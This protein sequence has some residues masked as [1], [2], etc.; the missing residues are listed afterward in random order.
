MIAEFND[1][2]LEQF[3]P[4]FL[5]SL[6]KELENKGRAVL[7]N[8]ALK[9]RANDILA[10][11]FRALIRRPVHAQMLCRIALLNSNATLTQT[12][13]YELYQS[14]VHLI[15]EREAGKPARQAID[16]RQ[17]LIFMMDIAWYFWPDKG[18][19]GFT[20]EQ[21]KS[22]NIQL[23]EKVRPNDDIH[24]EMLVGSL[25]EKK[26]SSLYYFAHRSFQEYL[27]AEYIISSVDLFGTIDKV[28]RDLTP[29]I[30]A[31][32]REST[33]AETFSR[34]LFD[35]LSSLRRPISNE[36]LKYFDNVADIELLRYMRSESLLTLDPK[37]SYI[38]ARTEYQLIKG[39]INLSDFANDSCCAAAL[40]G[41]IGA[42]TDDIN[43]L[44]Q[45]TVIGYILYFA[46]PVIRKADPAKNKLRN[47]IVLKS[48][49]EWLWAKSLLSLK[50]KFDEK[51]EFVNLTID[52]HLLYTNLNTQLNLV[53]KP[54]DSIERTYEAS[55]LDELLKQVIDQMDG[56]G[57]ER[58]RRHIEYR[59]ELIQFLRVGPSEHSFVF[60]QS[61]QHKEANTVVKN[62]KTLTLKR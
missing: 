54:F 52:F 26:A 36:L 19:T 20:L 23:P 4:K 60:D 44:E 57:T 29:E 38:L 40:L 14:F 61:R 41:L 6:N 37:Q 51:Q 7:S 50:S 2:Q 18:L 17:R 53:E 48:V 47:Q 30:A 8:E 10:D 16:V 9:T 31:F 15:L 21:L 3:V 56:A 62:R 34:K 22:A 43:F 24:R 39:I 45:R 42:W 32:I 25:L 55:R 46:K 59:K 1:N 12:S 27:I 33:Q 35:A 49:E 58:D 28:N 11:K 5:C 13:T